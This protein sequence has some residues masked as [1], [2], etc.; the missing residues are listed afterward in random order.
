[1]KKN[2]SEKTVTLFR[3]IWGSYLKTALVP[4]I[5]VEVAFISIYFLSNY[6]AQGKAVSFLEETVHQ[7]V[8]KIAQQEAR[9]I[10][11]QLSRVAGMTRLYQKQ[12]A[13]AMQEP[14]T[15][16]EEDRIRL[17]YSQEGTYYSFYDRKNGGAAVFYS[18]NVPIGDKEKLKVA[19]MLS[20]QELMKDII[21]S[22]P[23]AASIYINTFDSLNVIY[24][25]FDVISQYTP[26]IDITKFN[27]YYEADLIHNPDKKV[28][29]TEAYLDP[30]GHGWMASAI[31]P[32]YRGDFLE[33]VVGI[34]ITV[35]TII[36]RV[37][38]MEIPW[39]GYGMLI[40]KDGTILALPHKREEDW[41]LDELTHHH[42]EQA[43]LEDTFKPSEFNLYTKL[44]LTDFSQ[45]V[46]KNETGFSSISLGEQEQLV[47]WAT[48]KD[49][50]WKLLV[51]VPKEN[52]Y[53]E[54]EGMRKTL[55]NIGLFMLLGLAAF[56]F[57]F[58]S[59]IS[60]N[61][62]KTGG[63]ISNVL[64]KINGMVKR[65]GKGDYFQEV[66][67]FYVKELQDTAQHLV[68]MGSELG[69][70]NKRLLIVQDKLRSREAHLQALINSIDDIIIELDEE[71][72]FL[73]IWA[74]DH[75][76]L[77]ELFLK[78]DASSIGDIMDSSY[79]EQVRRKIKM[80]IET[81]GAQTAEYEVVTP[82]G[83]RWFEARLTLIS[84]ETKTLVAT[85]RDIT[86]YKKL[87]DS[88]DFTV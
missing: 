33:G 88:I 29:W 3:W 25:Y 68:S 56:Y 55:F 8:V 80:V 86:E 32:V 18:G 31:M 48:A 26:L 39:Q 41:G 63:K 81:R 52:V 69:H 74:N 65:I 1:M 58:L 10:D 84:S 43:I 50:E 59:F 14:N 57:V 67:H 76:N 22:E 42:Y 6:W 15:M 4:L 87:E 77:A 66:P 35:S 70:A 40:G 44:Q 61:A 71:G 37:L 75:D 9:L 72:R 64:L 21:Y 13:K 17:K 54:V 23:L 51:L 47:S 46:L 79:T 38:K 49:T 62:Y 73:N 85:I 7:E 11:E 53:A 2:K 28:K 30:A 82:K 27:F 12:A 24:P 60:F 16:E 19:Q 78:G 20:Q 34:D 45:K 5:I 83:T 36:S